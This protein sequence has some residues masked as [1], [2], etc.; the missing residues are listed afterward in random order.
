MAMQE[1]NPRF[2]YAIDLDEENRVKNVF[3]VDAKG[4]EDYQEFVDTKSFV[5]VIFVGEVIMHDFTK[6]FVSVIFV[7]EV[8]LRHDGW[9]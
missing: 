7:G 8:I 5:S 9:T 6:S 2:F 1:E 4:R 3:W